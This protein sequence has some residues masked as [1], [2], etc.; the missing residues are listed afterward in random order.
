[1][2]IDLENFLNDL[3]TFGRNKLWE[4]IITNINNNILPYKIDIKDIPFLYELCFDIENKRNNSIFYTPLDTAT[5]MSEYLYKLPQDT[6]C[7]IC[8]GCGNLILSYLDFIGKDKA[9]E[10]LNSGNV[11]LYDTDELAMR[12]C[13]ATIKYLYGVESVNNLHTDTRDFLNKEVILPNNCKVISNPPYGSKDNKDTQE[14]Y[15]A[16]I[17][18]ILKNSC[19][20]VLLTPFNFLNGDKYYRIRDLMNN[21][22]GFILPFDNVPSGVFNAN[23]EKEN[24]NNKI[25]VRACLIITE[26]NDNVKGYKVSGIIRFNASERD[27]IMSVKTLNKFIPTKYQVVDKYNNRYYRKCF[28]KLEIVYNDYTKNAVPL[29][30]LVEFN[31]TEDRCIYMVN[32][33]RYYT[34]ATKYKPKRD[35]KI[36]I[37]VSMEWEYPIYAVLNSSFA[38]WWWRMYDGNITYP[39]YLLKKLPI[40]KSLL[41]N[42]ELNAVVE[43][44]ISKE[45]DFLSYVKNKNKVQETVKFDTCYRNM[46]DNIILKSIGSIYDYNVFELIHTNNN[47]EFYL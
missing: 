33:C 18:K 47:M 34:V 17:E 6:V 4:N 24:T 21:Y 28:D 32:T 36:P 10:L 14:L 44:M 13:V 15:C 20:S 16:F 2:N 5:V 42:E 46:L 7:D 27:N 9:I 23:I 25:S 35:G 30:R 40:P 45:K 29:I 39:M 37:A 11:Y 43:E 19:A 38:Y 3:N 26:N 8:S 31:N 41:N 12:V 22:N 1:M